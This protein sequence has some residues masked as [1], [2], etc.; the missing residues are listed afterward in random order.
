M[1]NCVLTGTTRLVGASCTDEK[2][3]N[4]TR[5]APGVPLS[6]PLLSATSLEAGAPPTTRPSAPPTTRPS[7][8]PAG[9]QRAAK[10]ARTVGPEE[11]EGAA[12]EPMETNTGAE[13]PSGQPCS[14]PVAMGRS[15]HPSRSLSFSK[16]VSMRWWRCSRKMTLGS[17]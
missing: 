14:A 1:S 13:V 7:T 8:P 4:V 16:R 3:E 15:S 17:M 2:L 5:L 6:L 9:E 11:G 12:L 10:R